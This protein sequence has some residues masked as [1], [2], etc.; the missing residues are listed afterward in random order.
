MMIP[1]ASELN[2]VL[3]R[4]K[5]WSPESRARLVRGILETLGPTPPS[6]DRRPRRSVHELIGI[7][8]GESPPPDDESDRRWI[9]ERRM[10]KYG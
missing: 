7:G 10:E 6:T 8:T 9:D 2:D 5:A 1:V 3:D 4:V